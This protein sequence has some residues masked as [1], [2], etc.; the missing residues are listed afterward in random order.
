MIERAENIKFI[1]TVDRIEGEYA[2]CLMPDMSTLDLKISEY[3]LIKE[4]DKIEVKLNDCKE[5][6]FLR[7][8]P[9]WPQRKRKLPVR[10]VRFR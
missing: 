9:K 8:I 2:V 4:N 5:L 6:E 3:P 1:V 10:F 7:I